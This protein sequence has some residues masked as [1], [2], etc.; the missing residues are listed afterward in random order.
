MEQSIVTPRMI[1]DILALQGPTG[2][3]ELAGKLKDKKIY[4]SGNQLMTLM[5]DLEGKGQ[6]RYNP[7]KGYWESTIKLV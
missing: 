4:V 3:F 5:L 7:E 1:R 6:V 2:I